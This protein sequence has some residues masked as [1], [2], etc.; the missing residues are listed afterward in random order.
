MATKKRLKQF[1][2]MKDAPDWYGT[3]LDKLHFEWS[4]EEE[5]EIERYCAKTLKNIEEEGGMTPLERFKATFE[6]KPRDRALLYVLHGNV[7]GSKVLDSEA[8]AIKPID[9]YQHP[10]LW[11]KLNLAVVAR[12]K[13][14]FPT[15][16][17][18]AM[19][20]KSIAL[21]R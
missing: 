16:M 10:K 1:G 2:E 17:E 3:P 14:D 6:G 21:M 11:V 13:L 18:S 5:V 20:R 19:A 12:F 7:F 15:P 8:N 9:I 4:R